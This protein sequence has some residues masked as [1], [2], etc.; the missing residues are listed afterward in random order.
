[1]AFKF[2]TGTWQTEH[3][4]FPSVGHQNVPSCCRVMSVASHSPFIGDAHSACRQL[5]GKRHFLHRYLSIPR[6]A[7]SSSTASVTVCLSTGCPLSVQNC[8]TVPA[9]HSRASSSCTSEGSLGGADMDTGLMALTTRLWSQE[10]KLRTCNNVTQDNLL[11][12][13]VI[14]YITKVCMRCYARHCACWHEQE[15]RVY[16]FSRVSSKG[17]CTEHAQS[18]SE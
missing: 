13:S 6:I 7:A 12:S 16:T 3:G 14:F 15:T 17:Q 18:E 11:R 10:C 8:I 2:V 5:S 4:K 1:M 9:E